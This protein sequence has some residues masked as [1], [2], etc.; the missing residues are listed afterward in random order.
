LR[1]NVSVR[2]PIVVMSAI[3]ASLTDDE[4]CPLGER[5]RLRLVNLAGVMPLHSYWISRSTLVDTVWLNF[6]VGAPANG[7][8]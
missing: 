5:L 3:A 4:A 1:S 7:H 2:W 6:S 8:Y